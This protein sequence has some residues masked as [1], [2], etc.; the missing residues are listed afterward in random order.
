MKISFSKYH[1]AGNDFI[2]IDNRREEISLDTDQIARLCHRHFGIG[3]DGLMLLEQESGHDFRMIYYNADGNESTMCG[4]GGRCICVYAQK[5]GVVAA[6][7]DF[8]AKD[9]AHSA[10]IESETLVHLNMNNVP[11]VKH[12]SD[13]SVLDTGSPHYVAWVDDVQAVDVFHNGQ[14]IRNRPEFTPAGINV[15][16]AQ[17][18]KDGLRVRTYE[19]G[20]EDETLSCG[21]GVVAAAIASTGDAVGQFNIP[22]HNPGG[23]LSVSFTKPNANSATDIVLSGPVAFVFEGVFDTDDLA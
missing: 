12:A 1:G 16:F 13:H 22:V 5:L 19:R 17:R 20:V 4:N 9:G 2:L 18:T 7:A 21:T 23:K 6:K 14:T 3:A 11:D 10:I 15:N 8:V